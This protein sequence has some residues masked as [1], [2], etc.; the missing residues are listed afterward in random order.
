MTK[1]SLTVFS[2]SKLLSVKGRV[3]SF[4]G[5][6][7]KVEGIRG[8]LGEYFKIVSSN[9]KTYKAEVVGF[10]N[11]KLLLMP[12]GQPRGIKLGDGVFSLGKQATVVVG[13]ALLG[14]CIDP[15]GNPIDGLGELQSVSEV[16][17]Y[18]EP[19]SPLEKKGVNEF[20]ETKVSFIDS[21]L[22]CGIGQRLGIFA[23]SGVGK[24]TL[25]VQMASQIVSDVKVVVLVG[26]RGSEVVE[27]IEHLRLNGSLEKTIVVVATSEEPALVRAHA[28]YCATT[29]AE[30]FSARGNHVLLLVDSITRHAL[31]QREIGLAVGEP[32]TLRGYT[33]SVFAQLPTLVERA[34]NFKNGGAIT[35]IYTVLVE[36][37]ELD[38]PVS[39]NMRA[40]LDGHI[41]LSREYSDKGIYPSIDILASRSRVASKVISNDHKELAT[42]LK[43]RLVEYSK[44]KEYIE[45]TGHKPGENKN[46]DMIVQNFN[47]VISWGTDQEGCYSLGII[48]KMNDI[49]SS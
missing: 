11:S 43:A 28:L 44:V 27:L 25:F 30:Y 19:K 9:G 24:T 13:D 49:L 4:I 36:G 26:E 12:F 33:P 14:R 16:P 10:D 1:E 8:S 46:L 29:I 21:M 39:D 34:G 18:P 42:K 7:V 41:V 5:T 45:V 40:I 31:A 48:E 47:E 35:A 38:E 2:S 6:V 23:G 3:S 22:S 17:L 37:D 15:F 20:L 32:P